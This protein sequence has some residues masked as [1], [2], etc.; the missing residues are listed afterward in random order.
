MAIDLAAC[1]RPSRRF[2][3]DFR[4]QGVC[5]D[6]LVSAVRPGGTRTSLPDASCRATTG[7]QLRAADRLLT[8]RRPGPSWPA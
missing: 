4:C 1:T 5:A 7:A 3:T 8:T 2:D 6:L